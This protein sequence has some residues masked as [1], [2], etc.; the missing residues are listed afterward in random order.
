MTV[1]EGCTEACTATPD[2]VVC[3]RRKKLRGRS[4]PMEMVNGYCD[5]ECPGYVQDPQAG[6][7]WWSEWRDHLD[8]DH[9]GCMH[10]TETKERG[11]G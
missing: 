10:G 2:C 5:W 11:D 1:A 3:G 7:L 8:G 4:Y 6:H 9:S